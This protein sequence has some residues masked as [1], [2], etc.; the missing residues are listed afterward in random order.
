ML[1]VEKEVY[2]MLSKK[3]IEWKNNKEYQERSV[4]NAKK[5]V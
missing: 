5:E 1:I 4:W 3:S 2:G